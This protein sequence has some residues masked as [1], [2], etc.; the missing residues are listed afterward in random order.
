MSYKTLTDQDISKLAQT[1]KK[2][3]F[4][5]ELNGYVKELDPSLKNANMGKLT[6]ETYNEKDANKIL[7]QIRTL[8]LNQVVYGRR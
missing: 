8:Y 7:S 3:A 6:L 2:R 4:I 5:G 1:H